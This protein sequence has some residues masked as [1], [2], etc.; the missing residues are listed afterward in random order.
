MFPVR[1]IK[2]TAYAIFSGADHGI[3]WRMF[4]P[5]GMRHVQVLV[6]ADSGR[7]LFAGNGRSILV[8]A[9][10]WAF[11][12]EVLDASAREAAMHGLERGATLVL[13][14]PVDLQFSRE[15]VP[16][17]LLTCVSVAKAVMGISAWF[18]ITPAHLARWMLRNGATRLER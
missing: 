17:G 18:V 1:R 9:M 12:L 4:T 15:Y 5:R 13:E 10:S 11:T 7:A 8:N 2:F 14:W 16:R 3:F 6:P